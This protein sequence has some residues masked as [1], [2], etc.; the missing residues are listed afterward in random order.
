MNERAAPQEPR[1]HRR[2]TTVGSRARVTSKGQMTIPKAVRERM[3][4]RPGD[5]VEFVLDEDGRVRVQR[6]PK[7]LEE[8]LEKWSGAIHDPDLEGVDVDE[9][10]DEVRGR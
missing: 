6:D 3:D 7:G 2:E 10:L 1:A 9:W 4:I 8:A 5:D